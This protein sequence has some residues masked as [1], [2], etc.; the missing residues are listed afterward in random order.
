MFDVRRPVRG[1]SHGW[2][3]LSWLVSNEFSLV[4]VQV[5]GSPAE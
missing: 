5:F 2:V 3:V 4:G 1:S